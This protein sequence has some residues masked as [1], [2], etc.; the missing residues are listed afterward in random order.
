MIKGSICQ[1]YIT[2]SNIGTPNN[3][4]QKCMKHKLPR[5]KGETNNLIILIGD[6][7]RPLSN[8]N[9]TTKIKQLS[10]RSTRK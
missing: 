8:I 7:N 3:S 1:E 6:F 10:R 5:L 2:I 4:A 9:K